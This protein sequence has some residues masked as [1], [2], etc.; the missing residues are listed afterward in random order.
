MVFD[1]DDLTG[2]C[3]GPVPARYDDDDDDESGAIVKFHH[4]GGRPRVINLGER[5]R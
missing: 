3:S 4:L 5:S 2:F 1:D